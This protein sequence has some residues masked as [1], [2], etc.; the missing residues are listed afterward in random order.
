MK[1]V[2]IVDHKKYL[3][4]ISH[5]EI[6]KFLDLYYENLQVLRV[7]DSVDLSKGYNFANDMEIAVKK[8]E[9]FF[10]ATDA[11]LQVLTILQ[12]LQRCKESAAIKAATEVVKEAV[13]SV[14]S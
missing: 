7:G 2:A 11:I 14:G 5:V 4:E 12:Q 9:G 10:S 8:I 13:D 3:C 6:E 1:V